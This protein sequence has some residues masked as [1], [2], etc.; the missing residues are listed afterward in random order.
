M[1]LRAGDYRPFLN[2]IYVQA[3]AM[4]GGVLEKLVGTRR[5][6]NLTAKATR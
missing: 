3:R 2:S 1:V 5:K 6:R 4:F